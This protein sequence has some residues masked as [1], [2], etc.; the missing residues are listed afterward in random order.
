MDD[1]LFSVRRAYSENPELEWNR[2]TSGAQDRLE[3]LITSHALRRH[4][5]TP[6][7]TIHILDAGG[8]PGRYTIDLARQGYNLTLLD[9]SPALLTVARERIAE[10]GPLVQQHVVEI[11]E[12]S[13]TDLSRYPNDAFDAV[14]CL[15]GPL[16][17]LTDPEQRKAALSELSRVARPGA[18]IFVSVMNRFGVF[19]GMV[20]WQ[21]FRGD[22]REFW[23]T[24]LSYI[25][26]EGLA[27]P[28]Y[29]FTPDEFVASVQEYCRLE[30]LYGCNGIGAHLPEDHLIA[31]MA[32]GDHWPAWRE[33]LLE[34][35]DHPSVVGVSRSLLAV[36][37][38]P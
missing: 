35:A 2:L 8:G 7:A 36:A 25:E 14:L 12:G 1:Q 26:I 23:R 28:T 24:G 9:L 16:S 27:A 32:D 33:V 6:G 13:I 21:F 10:A 31:L 19:R 18:P 3:Y 34:T 15:G 38:K 22:L 11:A 29:F 17:H 5:P 37:R 20:Q 4:L 30:R